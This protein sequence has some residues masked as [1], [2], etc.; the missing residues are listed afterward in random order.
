MKRLTLAPSGRSL[1][2]TNVDHLLVIVETN[3]QLLETELYICCRSCTADLDDG[4]KVDVVGRFWET[5]TS[6]I[7]G[8]CSPGDLCLCDATYCRE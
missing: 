2:S 8:P 4:L 6:S 7:T 3:E 1:L 5:G